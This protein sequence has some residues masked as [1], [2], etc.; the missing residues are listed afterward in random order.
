M[1]LPAPPFLFIAS[2]PVDLLCASGHFAFRAVAPPRPF[3]LGHYRSG[4]C[5]SRLE[6]GRS[7][8]AVRMRRVCKSGLLY[9]SYPRVLRGCSR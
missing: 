5:R 4:R 6:L 8:C 1:V 7:D 3:K 2:R 9:F